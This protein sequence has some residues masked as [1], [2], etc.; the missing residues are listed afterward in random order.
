MIRAVLQKLRIRRSAKETARRL[1]SSQ[2]L[3]TTSDWFHPQRRYPEHSFGEWTYGIPR[4]EWYK[5]GRKLTVGRY[6]SIAD[7]VTILLGGNHSTDW[8]S[9]FPFGQIMADGKSLPQQEF[10]NGDVTI[11]NDVWIGAGVL[12]LSGITIG[13]GAVIGARSVV[14][15][16]IAPYSVTAGNPARHIRYRV[17]EELIPSLLEIGWWDW[18]VEQVKEARSLLLSPNVQE[19]VARFTTTAR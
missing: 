1:G 13:S 15:R 12:I 11:G 18:P 19:F 8:V 2:P 5:P 3:D 9:T 7:D 4:V 16:D 14:T 6:C 17:P 10:S